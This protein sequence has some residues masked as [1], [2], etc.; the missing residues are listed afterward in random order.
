MK[1]FT[2]GLCNPVNSGIGFW[3]WIA[4][5]DDERVREEHGS[6]GTCENVNVAEYTAVIRALQWLLMQEIEIATVH[7][8]SQL[9]ERQLNTQYEP[10]ASYLRLLYHRAAEL[11][12]LTGAQVVW[13]PRAQNREADKLAR[14]AFEEARRS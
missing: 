2:D 9:V 11:L 7:T 8:D 5:D 3:A 14:V 6:C 12:R 4:Y 1:V 10:C 13:I